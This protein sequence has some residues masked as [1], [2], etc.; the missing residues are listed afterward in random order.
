M[1]LFMKSMEAK[2][3]ADGR[4]RGGLPGLALQML[5]PG[6]PGGRAKSTSRITVAWY[7]AEHVACSSHPKGTSKQS[8]LNPKVS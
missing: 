8:C 4:D 2:A 7:P 1:K 5:K 3:G 6:A